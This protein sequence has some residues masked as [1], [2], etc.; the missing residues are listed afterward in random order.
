M[1]DAGG[2]EPATRGKLT[3]CPVLHPASQLVIPPHA[4]SQAKQSRDA[5]AVNRSDKSCNSR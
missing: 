2:V 4:R 5:S 1:C 3:N